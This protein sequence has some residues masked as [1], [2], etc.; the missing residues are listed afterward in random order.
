MSSS[1]KI[2]LLTYSTKPRGGVIHTME[3]A[4]ALQALGHEVCVFALNKDDQGFCRPLSCSVEFV[5][6][7]PMDRDDAIDTIVEQR[8]HDYIRYFQA[9][10]PAYD[11]YHAQDCISANALTILREHGSLY[12]TSN[13]TPAIIIRTVHHVDDYPSEYLMACQHRSIVQPDLCLCVSRHWQQQLLTHYGVSAGLVFNGVDAR[14]FSVQADGNETAVKEKLQ[15]TGT[16]LFLSIG[17]VEPRKNSLRLLQAFA[18]V[19]KQLPSAQLAIAG[20]VTMFNY[21]TYTD[22][23][24]SE[25][26]SLGISVGKSVGKAVGKSL[27]KTMGEPTEKSVVLTGV[28]DDQ[29]LPAL[30]RAADAF[31]FPSVMEGWGLVV[32]EAIASGLPVV[33]SNIEPFTEF[34]TPDQALL[35]DPHNPSAIAQGMLQSVDVAIAQPLV[36]ASQTVCETYT[37]ESSAKIHSEHYHSLL[38]RLRHA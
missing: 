27:E 15:L 5:P 8:I 29:D 17:G 20:G 13:K 6:A 11:I 7:Q 31:V 33:T 1:L 32:M 22:Q 19:Q 9:R 18:Q 34:L 37:W 24:F 12:G 36:A 4:E 30:Y 38:K 16:P 21:D 23:W 26:E 10:S 25:A 28:I 14:R 35:V 3:L 2:A